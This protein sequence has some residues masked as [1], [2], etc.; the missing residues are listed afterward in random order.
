MSKKTEQFIYSC[1][2][3]KKMRNYKRNSNITINRFIFQGRTNLT[4]R[5]KTECC[6]N[7]DETTPIS[8][9]S[10]GDNS[11]GESPKDHE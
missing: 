1:D 3:I 4:D 8:N 2:K 11:Q 7:C 6:E 9:S 5:L 10:H